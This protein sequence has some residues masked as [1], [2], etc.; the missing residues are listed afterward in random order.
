MAG[1][2]EELY[3]F[4]ILPIVSRL[5]MFLVKIFWVDGSSIISRWKSHTDTHMEDIITPTIYHTSIYMWRYKHTP[6]ILSS[7][8]QGK[9][10]TSIHTCRRAAHHHSSFILKF[11]C[12][13]RTSKHI[14][15]IFGLSLKKQFLL[16][17]KCFS[18]S[19]PNFPSWRGHLK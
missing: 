3:S 5:S 19:F 17:C 16:R 11:G 14:P 6:P 10:H 4:S 2:W 13:N 12:I 18:L 8:F 15:I 1:V 9:S 7:T